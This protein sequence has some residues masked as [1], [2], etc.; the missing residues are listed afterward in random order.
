MW[1]TLAVD[2]WF[3]GMKTERWLAES[4]TRELR[5]YPLIGIARAPLPDE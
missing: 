5:Y 3:G 1:I 4:K 2:C